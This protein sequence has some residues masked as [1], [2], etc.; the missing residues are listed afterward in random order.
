[1]RHEFRSFWLGER[2]SPL[3]YLCIQSFLSHGHRYVLYTYGSVAGL[4]PGCEVAD[5]REVLPEER[6]F[7]APGLA[8]RTQAGSP[9]GFTNLFRYK[10][11]RETGG[12]WVDTDV[13]CCRAEIPDSEYVFAQEQH[14]HYGSAVLRAPRGCALMS[15]ALERALEHGSDFEWGTVGPALLTSVIDELGLGRAGWARAEVYPWTAREALAP[16][17]PAQTV[18]LQR[19]MEASIFCHFWNEVLRRYGID[20]ERRPPTGSLLDRLYDAYDVPLQAG[21]GYTEAELVPQLAAAREQLVSAV[22]EGKFQPEVWVL[23]DDFEP[24]EHYLR[25]SGLLD[26]LRTTIGV[27]EQLR[28]RPISGVGAD[29][30]AGC[31]WAMPHL[32]E[33][34]L[35]ERVYAVEHS[36]HRLQTLG[37]AVLR[38]YAVPADA[39]VLHPGSLLELALP[40]HCLD[41]VL[42]SQALDDADDRKRLL[43]EVRRVLARDG[44]ALVI[45]EPLLDARSIRGRLKH[46]LREAG[47]RALPHSLQ[48]RVFGRLFSAEG[49]RLPDRW[50]RDP[51]TGDHSYLGS[52]YARLFARAG[53]TARHIPDVEHNAQSFV[54][55]PS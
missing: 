7:L 24:I 4:P 44:V 23:D 34:G 2:V 10:L 35:V 37:P 25:E 18:R 1:L 11:I 17:D 49:W 32:L 54:L 29:V 5:A 52:T 46:L 36:R 43:A 50:A 19:L 16:L 27:A 12:W 48:R 8:G 40:D 47:A 55:R 28:G 9:S 39:G 51:V 13:F 21:S 26:Q 41:F 15:L 33:S 6:V 45:G 30:A 53:F 3:E 31:L 38:H 20:K 42:M 22:R 14:D